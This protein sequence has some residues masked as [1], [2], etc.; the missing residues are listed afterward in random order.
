MAATRLHHHCAP[1]PTSALPLVSSISPSKHRS[2]NHSWACCSPRLR[3]RRTPRAASPGRPPAHPRQAG[4]WHR[5]APA[6]DG[7]Q[8]ATVRVHHVRR[9]LRAVHF[10]ALARRAAG[11]DAG[12]CQQAFGFIQFAELQAQQCRA[13]QLLCQ[14]LLVG[15]EPDVPAHACAAFQC[16]LK[17]S[18]CSASIAVSCAPARL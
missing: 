17:Y 18:R 14:R 16:G 3:T 4:R 8:R 5:R 13:A 6:P 9:K 1:R 2:A 10:V 12:L 15:G 7:R 11:R